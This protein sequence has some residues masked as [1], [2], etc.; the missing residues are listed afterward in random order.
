MA[1]VV[2]AVVFMSGL[3]SKGDEVLTRHLKQS[4]WKVP[5]NAR[6]NWP[7]KG[8]PHFLH[9]RTWPLADLLVRG[10]D[11]FRSPLRR[12]S[13]SGSRTPVLREGEAGVRACWLPYPPV[14]FTKV[15]VGVALDNSRSVP[16]ACAADASQSVAGGGC[17]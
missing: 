8:S 9:M 1:V 7:V 14:P 15:G 11:L 13:E 10:L 16:C 3:P 17:P 12:E 2:A 4:R 6:T 5:S